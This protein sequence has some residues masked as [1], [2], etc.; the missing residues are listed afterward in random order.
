MIGSMKGPNMATFG[1]CIPGSRIRREFGTIAPDSRYTISAGIG[2]RAE[3]SGSTHV[4][5][6]L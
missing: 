4:F 2:V 1:K 5:D 6:G 3:V